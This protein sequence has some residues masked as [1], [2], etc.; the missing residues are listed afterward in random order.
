MEEFLSRRGSKHGAGYWSEQA[1]EECHYDLDKEW[2][3]VK[4]EK[5][6]P[7][8]MPRL[9]DTIVRYNGKHI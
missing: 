8:Y 5:T 4:V 1:M 3:S 9:K 6:N 7:L 2:E